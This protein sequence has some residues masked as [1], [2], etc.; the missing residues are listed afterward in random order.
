MKVDVQCRT[1]KYTVCSCVRA[2]FGP[3]ILHARAVKGLTVSGKDNLCLVTMTM[4][5]ASPEARAEL[6]D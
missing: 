6:H 1:G 5:R 4:L 2:F 3:N